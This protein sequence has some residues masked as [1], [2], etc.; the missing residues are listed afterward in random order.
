MLESTLPGNVVNK[1]T[2]SFTPDWEL[3]EQWAIGRTANKWTL[4]K[5]S[6]K[7]WRSCGFYPT[8][9]ALLES[10]HRKLTRLEPPEATLV[11]HIEHCF[12]VA[13]AAADLFKEH[14]STQASVLSSFAAPAANTSHKSDVSSGDETKEV[15]H[16]S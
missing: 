12:D 7:R 4:Y 16:A 6:G 1:M 13:Q 8:P 15:S 10:F 5:S 9:E 2:S 14:V 11:E 3:T